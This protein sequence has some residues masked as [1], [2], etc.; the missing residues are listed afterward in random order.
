MTRLL[1]I[2]LVSMWVG[3]V[4]AGA[5]PVC[6]DDEA[7]R[8]EETA[9]QLGNW[10]AVHGAF[11]QYAQCDDG[12]ISEGFSESVTHLLARDWKRIEDLERL[13]ESDERFERFVLRHMDETVPAE[14]LKR[15]S[16]NARMRCPP[17]AAR[18]CRLIAARVRELF[19]R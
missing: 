5:P 11:R 3:N 15:I 19:S 12:A 16:E 6:T 4:H 1:A 10:R 18:L 2:A 8:A 13:V 14:E 17:K 9:A 7:L